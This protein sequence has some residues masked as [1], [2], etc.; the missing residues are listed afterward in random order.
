M[1]KYSKK[2]ERDHPTVKTLV[3]FVNLFDADPRD[4][5]EECLFIKTKDQQTVPLNFNTAQALFY[6]KIKQ[7]KAQKRPIRM[8]ILKA[9]QE[10][11][12]TLCEGLI[13]ERTARFENTN[14]LIVAHEPESTDAIFSMSKLFYDLLPFDVKPMRRYDNKKQMVFENPDEKG[15]TSNPGLRSRMVIATADKIKIGRGLTI[16][17]FHGSEVAFWKN[18]KALMLSVMQSI[19]NLPNTSV[20]LESTANGFGGDGEYFYQI[21]QDAL[22]GKNEFE[23]V[24]L[25]WHLM[26]EYSQPFASDADKKKFAET[27]DEYEK[28]LRAKENLTYEQLKWRRW[29]IQNLC[30][31]DTDKFKQEYPA[32]I[33]E[34]FVASSKAVIPKQYIE[35]QSK[36]T[37]QPIRKLDDILIYEEPNSRHFY[38]LGADPSEGIGQDDSA[39]TVIDK[40]TGREVGSYIGQIQPDL[41]AKK[42]RL[43]AELFNNAL[44]VIEINN[45]GL[46]VINA[47]KGEYTNI[48]QRTVFDKANNTKRK[49]LGWKTTQTTKPLMVDDFIA[50]LRD[51]DIGLSSKT[52]VSQMM[53]FVHTSES[54]RYGMGAETGQKD[55]CLISAMLAWQGLKELPSE[56]PNQRKGRSIKLY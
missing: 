3:D 22:A 29:A 31:G 42:I 20:F 41:F 34:S 13:F 9:R 17:N 21:V 28:D 15:R 27:L 43:S 32:T 4:F 33:E 38:S 52:T 48:Y 18:A 30:G 19:P 25:P 16:H 54:N 2:P 23:L 56:M 12:S 24:F 44:A 1:N 6:K 50:G 35:A 11:V 10:G 49:E 45:H 26:T 8:I 39:I 55:D 37:R 51:E 40:M 53:T 7:L 46:A 5:I 36:F 47:L 14:S